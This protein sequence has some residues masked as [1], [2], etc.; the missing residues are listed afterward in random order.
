MCYPQLSITTNQGLEA[1]GELG[2]DKEVLFSIQTDDDTKLVTIEKTSKF[3]FASMDDITIDA[4]ETYSAPGNS[5]D[6]VL[7]DG[8]YPANI[9]NEEEYV[10]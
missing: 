1:G 3:L 10:I 4:V 5:T 2:G 7:L 6:I 8:G 9:I